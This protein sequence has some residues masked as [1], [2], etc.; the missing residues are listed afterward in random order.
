MLAL[1][2]FEQAIFNRDPEKAKQYVTVALSHVETYQNQIN[3]KT[4]D[5]KKIDA[6]YKL[7]QTMLKAIK[8]LDNAIEFTADQVDSAGMANLNFFQRI[9]NNIS[10]WIAGNY[11]FCKRIENTHKTAIETKL[12]FETKLHELESMPELRGRI[13]GEKLGIL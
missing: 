6:L 4:K 10:T 11:K 5:Q 9:R 13:A 7:Y 2:Q 8:T 12:R 3:E 1:V